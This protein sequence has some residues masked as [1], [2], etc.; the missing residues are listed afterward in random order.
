MLSLLLGKGM[1]SSSFIVNRPMQVRVQDRVRLLW[2]R[3]L[4]Y[5]RLSLNIT[6]E[7]TTYLETEEV[8]FV[9]LRDK[10][11]RW[12][13]K[14]AQWTTEFELTQTIPLSFNSI[15]VRTDPGEVTVACAGADCRL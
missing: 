2:T 13:W 12:D 9:V 7:V 5:P 10:V 4:I 15:A 1:E 6:R 3:E 8:P 11:S 14:S